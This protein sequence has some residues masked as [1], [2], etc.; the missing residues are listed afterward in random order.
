[1]SKRARFLVI[2][3]GRVAKH[4]VHYFGQLGLDV[5]QWSRSS[6]KALEPLVSK[7]T[8]VL[9]LIS[10]R[11]ID[12]F[13]VSYPQ[14]Q[15]KVTVHFSGSV[16]CEG[17]LTAHPLMTFSTDLY[18]MEDYTSIPFICHEGGMAFED[19]LPGVPN[20]HYRIPADAAAYYH[21]LCVMANNFTSLLWNKCYREF[22]SKW[23]IPKESLWPIL[24]RTCRNL[25]E[26]PETALT[27]PLVRN[28]MSTINKNLNALQ[29][30][31]YQQVYRAFVDAEL[32][33][34]KEKQ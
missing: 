5:L 33:K 20:P 23:A 34:R 12:S 22:S 25:Q 17:V 27:G 14:L 3:D 7:A 13:Y 16:T 4:T 6:G 18:D 32:S 30:D 15:A 31:P 28:D 26:R 21:G 9:L 11:C 29:G 1:M 2:G 24:R 10:D 8:H 19:M